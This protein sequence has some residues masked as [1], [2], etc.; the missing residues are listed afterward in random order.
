[1][2]QL[3]EKRH[4]FSE[5]ITEVLVGLYPH[6]ESMAGDWKTVGAEF[7]EVF[8][9]GDQSACAILFGPT[10]DLVQKRGGKG[11]VVSQW[12]EAT[13]RNVQILQSLLKESRL[14]NTT[15]GKEGGGQVGEL[16]PF[17]S[18]R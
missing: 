17:L 11:L 7:S 15:K 16:N 18:V 5:E 6:F 12:H 2:T 9:G 13:E 4:L 1:M 10:G 8:F 3:S 14:G